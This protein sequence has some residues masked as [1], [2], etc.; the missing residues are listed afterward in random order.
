LQLYFQHHAPDQSS[1][2]I[3]AIKSKAG[4]S[5]SGYN[6]NVAKKTRRYKGPEIIFS[7]EA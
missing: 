7:L 1:Y 2:K 5:A 6:F 3:I 4:G